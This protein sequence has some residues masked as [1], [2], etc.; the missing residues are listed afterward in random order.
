MDPTRDLCRIDNSFTKNRT[1]NTPKFY[2]DV[3]DKAMSPRTRR[4]LLVSQ[5]LSKDSL[6]YLRSSVSKADLKY[7]IKQIELP[8]KIADPFSG[9]SSQK[10]SRDD[11]VLANIDAVFNLTRQEDGYLSPQY[12]RDFDYVD[13]GGNYLKYIQYRLPISRG[14]TQNPN[15]EFL[16]RRLINIFDN[17]SNIG[18]ENTNV[19]NN[20]DIVKYTLSVVADGVD[21]VVSD[22]TDYQDNLIKALKLCK[23]GA[24]FVSRVQKNHIEL[25]YI[26]AMCFEKFTLFQ[27]ISENLNL[28]FF[29][30]IAQGFKGSSSDWL[31]LISQK[32]EIEEK[33]LN[34]LQE[35][36]NSLAKLKT[37]QLP[38]YNI[39][40]CKAI[41]NIF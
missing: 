41:W 2:K 15:S 10:F 19:T 11:Y 3:S 21:L 20:D 7:Q 6:N 23:P 8:E 16:D 31:D 12:I 18:V 13:L 28:P 22:S 36:F 32:I 24:N 29:Y 34:Y 30:V 39:Y 38:E 35:F 1:L 5:G 4:S 33:F 17:K 40:K 14:F 26:T 27:P 37:E 25:F 9:I